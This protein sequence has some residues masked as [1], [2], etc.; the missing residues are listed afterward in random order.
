MLKVYTIP[1]LDAGRYRMVCS[2]I[3]K[4]SL[5]YLCDIMYSKSFTDSFVLFNGQFKSSTD[6]NLKCSSSLIDCTARQSQE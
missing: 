2:R 3:S 6:A 5:L 4:V 1:Y